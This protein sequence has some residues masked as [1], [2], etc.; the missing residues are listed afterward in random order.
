MT[1]EIRHIKE[2]E[3]G[4]FNRNIHIAFASPDDGF[5]VKVPL[6]WTLCAF[7]DGKLAT[8][9]MAWPLTM[10]FDG[11]EIPVAGV[12]MVG[13]LPI[14]RRR[15]HLRKVT[16][17]HFEIL[18]ERKQQ[19]ISALFA[20]MAAIY[21]RFGYGIVSSKDAYKVEPRR[22][23]FAVECKVHGSFYEADDKDMTTIL[24]IYQKFAM[25][26]VGYLKR[27]KDMKV[28]PGHMMTV[29]AMPP[30]PTPLM[31]VVY[32]EDGEPQ[33]Y[34]IYSVVGEM[35][36]G[37]Q[38]LNIREMAWLTPQAY[39]AIW[40]YFANMDL[41]EDISWGRVPPDDPLPHLLLEPRKLNTVSSDGLMARLVDVRR[42]LPLRPYAEEAALTFEIIDDFCPWN[43]GK[44]RL[45]M[46]PTGASV[47][48]TDE[49]PQ[50]TMPVSTLAMLMFG[51]ISASEAARMA[52][53]DVHDK[54][55]LETWNRVMR[56]P[57]RPYCADIF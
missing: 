36:P 51:Q 40:D 15:G 38:H 21:Q 42:A 30:S 24:D 56:T 31:K 32:Q 27:D 29:L 53:L 50:L 54:G 7:E 57:Y 41:V 19:P 49:S 35:G 17:Q 45:D 55:A 23:Q 10:C 1:L 44:W 34:V 2:D 13:T 16:K 22:L 46:S 4:A 12:S 39:R 11:V 52:R 20:S 5:T 37:G 6:E 18:Y 33:G 8:S 9:Y 14:Y 25:R 43:G 3:L 26:R 28:A 47:K 48:Q